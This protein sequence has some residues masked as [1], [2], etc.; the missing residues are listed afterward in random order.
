MRRVLTLVSFTALA[1]SAAFAQ[2]FPRFGFHVGGG[3]TEP[4]DVAGD[5]LNRGWN[6][7][8]GAGVNLHPNVGLMLDYT[9]NQFGVNSTSLTALGFPDGNVNMWSLTLNPTIHTNPRG[10]V[11]VYFTGGGGL[12]RWQQT[13]TRPSAATFTAFD[14]YFG[15]FYTAAVPVDVVLS[16]YSVMKPGWNGGMGV[17]FGTRW[18]AQVFAEARFHR[19]LLGNNR[20]LDTIPVTFGFRW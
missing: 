16:E 3:F 18:K 2:E 15:Y 11:D 14:P 10:P 5:R 12:Y 13:F 20:Y 1:A 4:T 6:V 17:A 8:V 9:Y 19:M 7:G